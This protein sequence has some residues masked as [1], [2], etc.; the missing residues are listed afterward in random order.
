MKEENVEKRGQ[1]QFNS[2]F[3]RQ[4]KVQV[5]MKNDRQ[6]RL[7]VEKVHGQKR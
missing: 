6:T 2:K 7:H 5:A 4:I 3:L 1:W